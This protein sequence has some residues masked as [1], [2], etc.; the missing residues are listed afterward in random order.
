MKISVRE[1]K[2]IAYLARL[3]VREEKLGLFVE[4]FDNILNYMD[5]LN[6]LDTSQVEA[7]Y[8]PVE[9]G[10]VLREDDP[11]SE[12]EREEILFNAPEEDGQYFIVPKVI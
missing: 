6:E 1:V 7:L 10:T 9:H 12:F 2:N 5:K 4:Q 3:E 11:G 8:S